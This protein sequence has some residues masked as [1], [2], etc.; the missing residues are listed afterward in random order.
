M[1]E[2]ALYLGGASLAVFIVM[3]ACQMVFNKMDHEEEKPGDLTHKAFITY[4]KRKSNV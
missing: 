1:I 2:L 4:I 3:V